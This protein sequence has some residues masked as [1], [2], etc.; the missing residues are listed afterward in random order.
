MG[1][2]THHHSSGSGRQSATALQDGERIIEKD[3]TGNVKWYNVQKGYGFVTCDDGRE[4]FLHHTG[5]N[6][7]GFTNLEDGAAV[8]FDIADGKRGLKAVNVERA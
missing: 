4:I 3:I 8:T 5:L 7:K 6:T 2:A 1:N